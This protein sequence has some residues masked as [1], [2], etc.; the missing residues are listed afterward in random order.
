MGL[1]RRAAADPGRAYFVTEHNYTCV[2]RYDDCLQ[3]ILNNFEE[4]FDILF[5]NHEY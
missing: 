2:G 1:G 3:I 5:Y 4:C